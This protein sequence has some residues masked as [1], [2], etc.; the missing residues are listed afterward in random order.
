MLAFIRVQIKFIK[1]NVIE[2]G[3]V[4]IEKDEKGNFMD[5]HVCEKVTILKVL[6]TYLQLPHA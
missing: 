4:W 5:T 2:I 3:F 6:E 1:A